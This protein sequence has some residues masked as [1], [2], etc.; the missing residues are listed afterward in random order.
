MDGVATLKGCQGDLG[1]PLAPEG[2][3]AGVNGDGL[4]LPWHLH[5]SAQEVSKA[6]WIIQGS[7]CNSLLGHIQDKIIRITWNC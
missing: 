3:Q 1:I 7:P 4:S 2:F 6:D 5:S